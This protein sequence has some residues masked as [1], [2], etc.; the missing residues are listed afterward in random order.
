M[1]AAS[2]LDRA[3]ASFG[4]AL[5][6][7]VGAL[8]LL[9]V[10]LLVA[11]LAGRVV[12]RALQAI[13]VDRL[14]ERYG[15]QEVLARLGF[16][17][18]LSRL[19]GVAVRIAL[20]VVVLVAALSLL[21]LGALGRSLNEIVLFLPKLFV[22]LLLVLAGFVIGDFVG[23]WVDRIAQQMAIGGPLGRVTQALIAAISV[24]TALAQLGVPTQILTALL[25]I[26]LVAGVLTFALAFGLGGRDVARQLSAG[27]YVGG[28]FAVG[29]TIA[30]GQVRGEI[31]ALEAAAVVLRAEDGRTLRVPN[32]LLLESVVAVEGGPRA[33][34]A[35]GSED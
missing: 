10:G 17:R 32:N 6:G 12:T 22:A 15:I 3:W 24:L 19:M 16:E 11:L 8:V 35:G 28:A 33:A 30:V 34:G 13:G 31:V 4:E 20:S 14:G 25:G 29:Q 1:I 5:P 7:I 23:R 2:V 9:V 18:S 27:R 26:A 21:G